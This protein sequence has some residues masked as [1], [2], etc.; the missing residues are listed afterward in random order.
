[1]VFF[2]TSD[3]RVHIHKSGQFIDCFNR[4]LKF[5]TLNINFNVKTNVGL[6]LYRQTCNQQP[7]QPW[8]T[9]SLI[10]ILAQATKLI[11]GLLIE[12]I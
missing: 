1:M 10:Y 9:S 11:F 5:S 12:D 6:G 3:H 7:G 4:Y 8:S 2:M